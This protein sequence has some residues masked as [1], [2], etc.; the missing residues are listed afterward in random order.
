MK[1]KFA[2]ICLCVQIHGSVYVFE[3]V[4]VLVLLLNFVR[5]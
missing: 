5:R 2:H 3:S 4:G 1:I